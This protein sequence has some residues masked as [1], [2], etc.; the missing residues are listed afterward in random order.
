M[1]KEFT[2]RA[3]LGFSLAL[4]LLISA[5]PAA[6]Q[7]STAAI[8][9]TVQDSSGAVIPGATLVLHNIATNIDRTAATNEAGNYA[10]LDVQ[11]GTYTLKVSKEGFKSVLQSDITL[12]VNQTARYDFTLEVGAVTQQVNVQASAAALQAG[13]AEL[14]TAILKNDVNSLPLNGRNFTQLLSLTPGVSTVN[15]SQNATKT[16]GIWSNPVG[17]FTYPSINGQ[18]NRSNYFLL[19]GVTD[20]GSFG[21]TYAVAPILETVQEFK[22]QSHN[23]DAQFGGVL[24]GVINVVTKSGTNQYHGTVF[25][26]LRNKSLD[27]RNT[28]FKTRPAFV[29]NQY[30]GTVGGPIIK[31]KLFFYGGYEGFRSVEGAQSL[32]KT[33]TAAQLTGDLSDQTGQIFNPFSTRPDPNNPGLF[34][35]DAFMC[36]ASGNPLPAGPTG[37]QLAGTACNKIPQS[38][39]DPNMVLYAQTLFPRPE[40]TGVP[41]FNGLDT[42]KRFTGQDTESLR[43]D[44]QASTRDT[45]W[46]RYTTFNQ[47]QTGSA[48][49]QTLGHRQ[50]THGY[51]VA[52]HYQH[53][54]SGSALAEFYFGRVSG[55]INQF[56]QFFGAPAGFQNQTGFSPNFAGNFRG[57]FSFIPYLSILGFL[58]SPNPSAHD[59]AQV[60]DTHY[61]DIWQW[62]GTFSKIYRNHTLTFGA[63]I[64]RNNTDALY[65]NA[66]EIFSAFN[67]QDLN[68]AN[69]SPG[70]N[71]LASF[72]LGIPNSSGRRNVRETTRG[73]WEDNFY[74]KDQWKVTPKLTINMGLRYDVTLIPI[75]GDDKSANGFVGDVDL[76][77]GVYILARQPASCAVAGQAPCIPGGT[78]PPGVILTP[79]ANGRIY[80]QNLDNFQPRLGIAYQ[81][82][83]TTVLRASYGR[84]Y[85]NWAAI[86][87]T[88]Q[89]YEGTWPDIGQLLAQNLNTT[90]V[91]AT[92]EDPLSL[93]S[94]TP[95]PGPTPFNQVQWFMDP[96]VQR[97]YADQWN[98]GVQQGLWGNTVIT[99]NYAGS[100]GSRLDVG[101]FQNVARTPGPG[102]AATVA[103]RRPFP[104]IT[105]TFFDKSIGRSSYNAFQFSMRRTGAGGL[106]YLISYTWSKTMDIG[107]SGWYG[108]EGCSVQDPFNLDNDKSFSAFDLTH[109]FTAS[110]VYQLPF[111]KGKRF[112]SGN[113]VVDALAGDWQVNGITTYTSGVPYDVGI[114]G[115]I[116]NTG[117]GGCCNG[118]YERLNL[119]GNPNPANRTR[120][121]YISRSSFGV[122][123]AF[124]F[125]NLGRDSLRS[126]Y[127][128]N[129]DFSVFREFP[130]PA[131]GETRHLEFR[132]ETFNTFNAT[133]LDI[134]DRNFTDP[135][136]GAV[137]NVRNIPRQIQFSLKFYF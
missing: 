117:N 113:R 115:D 102:D 93:G 88:S 125:G 13:S 121:Q 21:S 82:R 97:P 8:T 126:A 7:V 68:P 137:S 23:D 106:S 25:E 61:A 101:A 54:F 87:Q 129:W 86:T 4:A 19:D 40:N 132:A 91:T 59:Q 15:V 131:L 62:G 42:T 127:F 49:F 3:R 108:V 31:N 28:F 78:L 85:D 66:S 30:G 135:N 114:S 18:T 60:D 105:P 84:F 109:I 63:E 39:L 79:F 41:G 48:A 95:L 89:N 45:V 20:Q 74:I 5:S 92:A 80:T 90:T 10:F 73:G 133:V 98:L 57:G 71:A 52:A 6:A 46:G 16:G 38:L 51:S 111:G 134:P 96:N 44:Y 34:I 67:T 17:S 107:C 130:I 72:L 128:N 12:V 104:F 14:G 119:V 22:V 103:S 56:S 11:P 122:P 55:Q 26:F 116:A 35:R 24:G 69:A 27:A 36:D 83:P 64:N 47:L 2:F 65:L 32:F 43:L 29:Q 124:T 53:T 110:W 120:E 81:L 76:N 112:S 100:H 136:F 75:Y 50:F 77:R 33:P 37:L 58:G 1:R 70:G 123:A 94:S 9:G 118:Y 99:A